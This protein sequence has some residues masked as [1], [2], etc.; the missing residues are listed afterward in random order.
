MDIMTYICIITNCALVFFTSGMAEN[1]LP[2]A[3]LGI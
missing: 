3:S 2:G 1:M